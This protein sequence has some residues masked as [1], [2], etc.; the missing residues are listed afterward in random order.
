MSGPNRQKNR[1]KRRRQRQNRKNK[2]LEKTFHSFVRPPLLFREDTYKDKTER[3]KVIESMNKDI[4]SS[5]MSGNISSCIPQLL[6]L[7]REEPQLFDDF[8]ESEEEEESEGEEF[9]ELKNMG[10]VF[11]KNT[12]EEFKECLRKIDKERG[13]KNEEGEKNGENSQDDEPGDNEEPGNKLEL[14][15]PSKSIDWNKYTEEDLIGKT[16]IELKEIVRG[17]IGVGFSK[18]IKHKDVMIRKI[19][20][21]QDN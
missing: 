9:E 4:F 10:I 14:K 16:C 13:E 18:F 20:E 19:L 5:L 2:K 11:S 1:D 3:Q 12:P 7:K 15:W 6:Y 17:R 21:L 8:Y